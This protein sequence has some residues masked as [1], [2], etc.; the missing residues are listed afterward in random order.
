[1]QTGDATGQIGRDQVGSPVRE[2]YP[3]HSSQRRQQEAF[4]KHLTDDAPPA[5]AKRRAQGHLPLPRRAPNEQEV[6]DV[7]AGNQQNQTNGSEQS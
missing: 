7:G 4:A 3:E 6:R 2:Q 5:S 1:V